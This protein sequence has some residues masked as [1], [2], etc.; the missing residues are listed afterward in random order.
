M[1]PAERSE[2]SDSA[3][4]GEAAFAKRS[5]KRERDVLTKGVLGHRINLSYDKPIE[6]KHQVLSPGFLSFAICGASGTGKTTILLSILPYISR[7]NAIIYCSRV[8]NTNVFDAIK[9]WADS[10]KRD[11][12]PEEDL[13]ELA[14]KN[15]KEGLP[16]PSPGSE[17]PCIKFYVASTPEEFLGIAEPIANSQK[18]GEDQLY[19]SINIFD[20]FQMHRGGDSDKYLNAAVQASTML[21]NMNFHCCFLAQQYTRGIPTQIRTNSNQLIA[22]GQFDKHA[23]DALM[24]DMSPLNREF[25]AEGIR[26]LY[27]EVCRS[28][29]GFLW[30]SIHGGKATLYRYLNDSTGLQ[31]IETPSERTARSQEEEGSGSGSGPLSRLPEVLTSARAAKLRTLVI[32]YKRALTE[33][34][35]RLANVLYRRITALADR[36][37]EGNPLP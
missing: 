1:E 20:D 17:R 15:E 28:S 23:I 37:P 24:H 14:K 5:A 30:M 7:L 10:T 26:Y 8:P 13:R 11:M 19:W 4:S 12:V 3:P 35:H 6:H 36:V 31:K 29:H 27:E 22:F 21:R 25:T 18:H 16:P 9:A 2:K 32:E 33:G 34:N